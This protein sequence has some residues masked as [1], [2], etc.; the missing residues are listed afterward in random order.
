[1]GASGTCRQLRQLQLEH[2]N[3]TA[4]STDGSISALLWLAKQLPGARSIVVDGWPV[5]SALQQEVMHNIRITMQPALNVPHSLSRLNVLSVRL[6]PGEDE[7]ANQSRSTRHPHMGIRLPTILAKAARL[8]K[9]EIA[10]RS[11]SGIPSLAK[12]KHLALRLLRFPMSGR[13]SRVLHNMPFLETLQLSHPSATHDCSE[14]DAMLVVPASVQRVELINL[15]PESLLLDSDCT[16][17]RLIGQLCWLQEALVN[18]ANVRSQLKGLR[19]YDGCTDFPPFEPMYLSDLCDCVE[20]LQFMRPVSSVGDVSLHG[21]P[22]LSLGSLTSLHVK[23]ADLCITVPALPGLKD[24]R[25]KCSGT[26]CM[27]FENVQVSA[28]ALLGFEW[29]YADICADDTLKPFLAAMK[30][31][32]KGVASQR[33]GKVQKRLRPHIQ[34]VNMECGQHMRYCVQ[35]GSCQIAVVGDPWEDLFTA[36]GCEGCLAG[37]GLK[38][39]WTYRG[40]VG[41]SRT[42][43]GGHVH[44]HKEFMDGIYGMSGCPCDLHRSDL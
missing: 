33:F 39:K 8:S 17:V 25:L 11:T 29:V 35:Y 12:L 14:M 2:L 28:E 31:K 20:V 40:H 41:C 16:V 36:C 3:I 30:A 10:C 32:G 43:S 42:A 4:T 21:L 26:L 5:N 34:G 1:M 22:H 13:I 23:M 27:S 18:W 24:L 38:L 15:Y 7:N 19:L 9:L 37:L 6:G 44:V